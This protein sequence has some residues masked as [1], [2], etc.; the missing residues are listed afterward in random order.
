MAFL[1]FLGPLLW[2]TQWEVS[3]GDAM[4]VGGKN[5]EKSDD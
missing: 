2:K 3:M 1:P 4:S 5:F